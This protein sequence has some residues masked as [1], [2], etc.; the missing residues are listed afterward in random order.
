MGEPLKLGDK[1]ATESK[2]WKEFNS[3]FSQKNRDRG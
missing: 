1:R 2:M 3:H